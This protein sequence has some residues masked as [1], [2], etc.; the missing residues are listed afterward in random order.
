MSL[1]FNE[2]VDMMKFMVKEKSSSQ[3]HR[4]P[5]IVVLGH[6][7]HGKTTL[8]DY[9][10]KS[11]IAQKEPGQITQ[12]IGAFQVE[13]EGK[14]F[15][16]ID[17]PGHEAFS[18]VRSCGVKAADLAILLIAAD[19][20]IKE[21]TKEAYEQ[22]K[23]CKLPFLVALNKID[24]PESQVEKVKKQLSELGIF[25]EGW[26]GDVPC[27]EISAKTGKGVK[28]MMELIDLMAQ[29]QNITAH[30]NKN[31]S[32][33]IISSQV[34]AKE[35]NS[36]GIIIKDGTLN[37]GDFIAT[38]TC[39]TKAVV[40]T[41]YR[42][43]LIKKA[44]P[45]SPVKITRLKCRPKVGEEFFAFKSENEA[46][47][48]FKQLVKTEKP[49]SKTNLDLASLSSNNILFLIIKAREQNALEA[50]LKSIEQLSNP[51][52]KIKVIR[53]GLGD[54]AP[55][56]LEE[57]L[58]MKAKIYGFQVKI[59]ANIR[60]IAHHQGIEVATFDVIY[61]LLKAIKEKL[62]EK[63]PLKITKE[64]IGSLQILKI[65]KTD[66][67]KILFG[68]KVLEGKALRGSFYEVADVASADLSPKGKIVGL[69]QDKVDTEEVLK[70]RQCGILG[71][72]LVNLKEG[73]I[74]N[75]FLEKQGKP[76][77]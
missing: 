14:V 3:I 9:L 61:D 29:V 31:A 8:L 54:I 55:L 64:V 33:I 11:N 42:G 19:E 51:Y 28:E 39:L 20:G 21:Q 34:N 72:G 75:I 2:I 46:E 1:I 18:G 7:D 25:L 70:G 27:V 40:I 68:G 49:Q 44:L 56:D 30:S 45:S 22:I 15:T 76:T 35:G 58:L 62:I 66:K 10:R 17:T 48:F 23:N 60:Q 38:P 24:K 74:I 77:I 71:E 37:S 59:P 36:A 65:F 63:L 26:G 69:Q 13:F 12:N 57:A 16:F 6:V 67:D 50:V 41:D 73:Q 4:P 32:G 43:S 52:V 53:S 5:V 47:S